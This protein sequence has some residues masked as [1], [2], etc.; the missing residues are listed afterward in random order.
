MSNDGKKEPKSKKSANLT[1]FM[2]SQDYLPE[3]WEW[4]DDEKNILMQYSNTSEAAKEI[5]MIIMN[6]LTDNGIEVEEAYAITHDK[7]EHVIWD[8]YKNQ[9]KTDFAHQH[10]HFVA[11]LKKG[12]T[13]DKIAGYI[14]VEPGFIEKPKAG[15]YSYDNQL[16][17]LIHIK[18]PQKY[19]YDAKSVV[20]LAGKDYFTKY[21]LEYHKQ[22]MHGRAERIAKE[23]NYNLKDI[24]MMI[25]DGEISEKDLVTNPA[26]KYTYLMHKKALDTL[27]K[28]YKEYLEDQRKAAENYYERLDDRYEEDLQQKIDYLKKS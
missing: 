25:M 9:Y 2:L 4:T 23:S 20:T 27:V 7:D 14:G 17:Y 28:N 8:E 26:F 5:G 3:H 6:R 22:W 1:T 16:S 15:R 21:Y 12:D 13:L 11:K 24:Q 19:R 10:I 18:Y